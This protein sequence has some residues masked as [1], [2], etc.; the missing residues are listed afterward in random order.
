MRTAAVLAVAGLVLTTAGLAPPRNATGGPVPN[1]NFVDLYV[2]AKIER[3]NIPHSP[4]SG[5][6]EFFR[7]VH[8]DLTCR[9]PSGEDAR[10]FV[11]SDA[12]AKRDKL[13]DKLVASEECAERWTYHL[14]DLWCASQNRIGWDGR[15]V[16]HAYVQDALRF[17]QP[18]GESVRK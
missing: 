3:D 15:N 7:R 13:M 4:L 12:P 14:L 16:F 8:I 6:A 17:N 2:F 11:A 10:A 1:K 9:I 18:F 5:D